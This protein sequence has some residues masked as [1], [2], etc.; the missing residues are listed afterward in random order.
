VGGAGCTL[1][2]SRASVGYGSDLRQELFDHIQTFSYRNLDGFQQGSLITRLTSD[3][4]QMQ[5]FVQMLLR[6]F[7]RSPMLII[8]SVIMAFTISVKLAL[9]LLVTMPVLFILLYV[10]IKASYPLFAG[11]QE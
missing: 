10:L 11:V 9:I 4:T 3:I 6:M 1:F 2:S 5:T 7:I 8:G